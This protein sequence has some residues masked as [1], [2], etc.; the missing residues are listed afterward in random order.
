[1]KF[2]KYCEMFNF[3]FTF[4]FSS[5]I[6]HFFEFCNLISQQTKGKAFAILLTVS[7]SSHLLI[8]Q[9]VIAEV[10]LCIDS[11]R[12]QAPEVFFKILQNLTLLKKRLR[13]R[14]FPLNFVKFSRTPFF[15]NTIGRL[16]LTWLIFKKELQN[17][18]LNDRQ[19]KRLRKGMHIIEQLSKFVFSTKNTRESIQQ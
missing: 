7:L 17:F 5:F 13:H 9:A 1:M 12:K 6:F 4:H 19:M 14:C 10:K 15:Q 11:W 18:L 2:K 3:S 8:R 16:L